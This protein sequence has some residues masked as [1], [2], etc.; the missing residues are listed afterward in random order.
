MKSKHVVEQIKNL[1]VS[2]K[3]KVGEKLPN[4][5]FLAESLGVS[6]IIVREA[7]SYLKACGIIESRQGSGNYVLKIPNELNF[8]NGSIE[9]DLEEVIDA[10]ELLESTIAR[11]FLKNIT[12]DM[13]QDMEYMVQSMEINFLRDDLEKVIESDVRFHQIFSKAFG[14]SI[15]YSFLDHLTD[16][17]KTR[18][19]LFLKRDYLWDEEYQKRSIENHRRILRAV[20]QGSQDELLRAIKLHYDTIREH[21][22]V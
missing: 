6:R 8:Q 19:W 20:S 15:V 14:N 16:Y 22:E 5:R 21:L 9:Y 13:I 4:E 3:L 2:Q 10:R 11:M 18:I 1:I 17:M 12:H 7:L